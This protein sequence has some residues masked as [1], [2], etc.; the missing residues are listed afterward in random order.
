[1]IFCYV[2]IILCTNMF[3]K[4]LLIV[5]IARFGAPFY[6]FTSYILYKSI[7]IFGIFSLVSS[8]NWLTHN[9]NDETND[10]R[11]RRKIYFLFICSIYV[12]CT[13]HPNGNGSSTNLQSFL[14]WV[15]HRIQIID[16]SV[17]LDLSTPVY[18]IHRNVKLFNPTYRNLCS[19]ASFVF[20]S[21]HGCHCNV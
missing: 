2:F 9:H 11:F 3:W 15:Q 18:F 20:V 10:K 19:I 13:I 4:Q 8:F 21:A 16:Q 17:P 14:S 1:M 12:Q 5:I 6:A 7:L